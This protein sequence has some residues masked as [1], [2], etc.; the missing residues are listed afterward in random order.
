MEG[1]GQWRIG[2]VRG[3]WVGKPLRASKDYLF[4]GFSIS[5]SASRVFRI[6]SGS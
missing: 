6:F 4:E 3:F 5:A 2:L 1:G